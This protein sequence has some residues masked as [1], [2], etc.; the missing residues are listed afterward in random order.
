MKILDIEKFR[1]A[2]EEYLTKKYSGRIVDNRLRA[3]I[4]E[5]FELVVQ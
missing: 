2:F 4:K 3:N 5:E 1:V